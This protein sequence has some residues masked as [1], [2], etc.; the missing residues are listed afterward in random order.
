MV[1]VDGLLHQPKKKLEAKDIVQWKSVCPACARPW[2]QF[3]NIAN[4]VSM[5][6]NPSH[7]GKDKNDQSQT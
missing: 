3:P 1:R 4:V 2:V 5:P 7:S 6:L